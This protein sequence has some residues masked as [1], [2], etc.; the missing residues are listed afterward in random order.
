M[1][2]E[3]TEGFMLSPQQRSLWLDQQRQGHEYHALGAVL[4][5]GDLQ[6]ELLKSA[7][8]AVVDR[9][10]ILRTTFQQHP[11]MPFPFQVVQS[12]GAQPAWEERGLAD[13]GAE[14]QRAA[15]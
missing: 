12:E 7:V 13:L 5:E 9:H 15:I 3:V 6:S 10:E 11:G 4:I 1:Q 14:E 8:Q 2:S